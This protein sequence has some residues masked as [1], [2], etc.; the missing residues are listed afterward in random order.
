MNTSDPAARGAGDYAQEIDGALAALAGIQP[1]EGLAQRVH[2]RI[3]SAP[4]LPWYRRIG[5]RGLAITPMGH[6]RWALAAASALIVVGGVAMTAYHHTPAAAP[7]PVA[8][9]APHPARQPAAAAASV[10]ASHHPLETN[11]TKTPHR[12]VHRSYRA[13]HPRVPL[14]RGTA[15]PMRPQT[16]PAPQ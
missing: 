5:Y 6:Q 12:G 11:K 13:M 15:A 14:P 3:A 1:R 10:G 8:I 2:A 4:E 9:Q 16:V 7:A